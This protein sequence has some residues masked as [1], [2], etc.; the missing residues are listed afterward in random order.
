VRDVAELRVAI[1]MLPAFARLHVALQAVAEACAATSAALMAYM[2]AQ[3]VERHRQCARTPDRSSAAATR[4]PRRRLDQG[5]QVAQQCRVEGRGAL[6]PAP[7]LPRPRDV[8][9]GA[10]RQLTQPSLDGRRGDPGGTCHL[11]DA[12]V[13]DRLRFG[14]SPQTPRSLRQHRRQGRMFGAEDGQIHVR[15]VPCAA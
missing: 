10:G 12:A 8:A 1:D 7:G 2:M 5:I 9:Q 15:T 6:P 3:G 13:A 11:R 14:R 4:S